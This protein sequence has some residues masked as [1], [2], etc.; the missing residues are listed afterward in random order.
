MKTKPMQDLDTI[1]KELENKEVGLTF[2]DQNRLTH[3]GVDLHEGVDDLCR[4]LARFPDVR[5]FRA[6][7]CDLS[8]TGLSFLKPWRNLEWLEITKNR[9]T[10]CGLAVLAGFPLLQ[11][12]K[13]WVEHDTHIGAANIAKCTNLRKLLLATS[14]RLTDEDLAKFKTLTKL[15]EADLSYLDVGRGLAVVMSMPKMTKLIAS[16]TLADDSLCVAISGHPALEVLS[17]HE[18]AITDEGLK[19]LLRISSLKEL[20]LGGTKITS[21]GL[22]L[23]AKH[24]TLSE[25]SAGGIEIT[26]EAVDALKLMSHLK[27]FNISRSKISEENL[28]RLQTALPNCTINVSET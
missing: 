27:W 22:A 14:S 3:V 21:R 1:R 25:I 7:A 24:K 23:C 8:D 10:S 20:G 9:V 12:L 2:D 4:L 17:C 19:H 28:K 5:V 26:D 16:K 13:Y 11:R 18:T 15:E 6:N